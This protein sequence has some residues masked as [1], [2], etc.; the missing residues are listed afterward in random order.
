[1]AL[2]SSGEIEIELHH[3]AVARPNIRTL[4]KIRELNPL[5]MSWSNVCDYMQ[6]AEFHALASSLSCSETRHFLLPMN[7]HTEVKGSCLPDY[8]RDVGKKESII[9]DCDA[10]I[11]REYGKNGFDRHFLTPPACNVL[12][13]TGGFLLRKFLDNW[14]AAFFN[15]VDIKLLSKKTVVYSAAMHS[16]SETFITFS[17][18][19]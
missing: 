13:K 4:E 3:S 12:N 5:S 17:Y 16:C 9:V 18:M 10:E 1:M 19:K 6:P 7:L 8:F 14:L 15:E 2:V 11:C